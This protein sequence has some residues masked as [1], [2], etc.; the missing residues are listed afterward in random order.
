M[1]EPRFK[2]FY[3]VVLY[4]HVAR[5][6]TTTDVEV[7]L[8]YED[9]TR[10]GPMRLTLEELGRLRYEGARETPDRVWLGRPRAR[11]STALQAALDL[12]PDPWD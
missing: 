6:E 9:G 1:N 7:E 12:V 11:W 4:R 2:N 5:Y 8:S 10:V 3:G